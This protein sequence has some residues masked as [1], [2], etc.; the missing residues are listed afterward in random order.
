MVA[1]H[2]LAIIVWL[3]AGCG[4][5][6][7][8]ARNDATGGAG[9]G[10]GGGGG[11]GDGPGTSGPSVVQATSAAPTGTSLPVTFANDVTAGNVV[12]VEFDYFAGSA[13]TGVSD[14]LGSTYVQAVSVRPTGGS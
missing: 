12:I 13:V 5:L 8:D 14:T 6:A 3:L 1:M 9:G 7:F 4:R 11:G 10:G 2:R